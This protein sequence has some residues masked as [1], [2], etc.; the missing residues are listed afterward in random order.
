MKRKLISSG[1]I[2][3]D[4]AGYSRAVKVGPYI[5]VSGTVAV[6]GDQLIG[7]GDPYVQA[8]FAL[9]K[10]EKALNEAGAEMKHVVRTRIYVTRIE[11][12]EEVTKAHAEFFKTIKPACTLVQVAGL[13]DENYL[14]EIEASAILHAE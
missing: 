4:K 5:E 8:K 14:V 12:W 13:I 2:W 10:I 3:E 1:A 6:D 7:E 9:Q 11:D